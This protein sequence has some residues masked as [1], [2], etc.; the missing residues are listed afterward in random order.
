M[1]IFAWI[2]KKL[3]GTYMD[4]RSIDA[5]LTASERGDVTDQSVKDALWLATH[6]E[7]LIA[8]YGAL[9]WAAVVNERVVAV[10]STANEAFANA[11]K[12]HPQLEPIIRCLGKHPPQNPTNF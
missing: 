12:I 11:K 9:Q 3:F 5:V 7:E 4:P 1:K 6:E 10:A 2:I 8:Q